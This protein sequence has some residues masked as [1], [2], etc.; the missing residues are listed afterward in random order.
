M[1]ETL[2]IQIFIIEE[3]IMDSLVLYLG[4]ASKEAIEHNFENALE[5]FS[6]N[7]FFRQSEFR[8]HIYS[9]NSEIPHFFTKNA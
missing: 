5:H 7:N 6:L 9:L 4:E 2:T 1:F 8:N 3:M